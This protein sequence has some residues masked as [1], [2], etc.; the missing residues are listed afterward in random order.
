MH[1]QT[2]YK[3]D[4]KMRVK[5]FVTRIG[6]QFHDA[7]KGSST[8][9]V[10]AAAD[11]LHPVFRDAC[12]LE[13]LVAEGISGS[14]DELSEHEMHQQ[15]VPQVETWQERRMADF[16]GTY[17]TRL[18]HGHASHRLDVIVPAAEQGRVD[19]LVVGRNRRVW[20]EWDAINSVA[21]SHEDHQSGDVDLLDETVRATLLHGG[22]VHATAP[23]NLIEGA[24]AAAIL[25]W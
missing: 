10:L 8:P 19:A 9:L 11:Y 12:P 18:A 25:R 23:E 4:H 20:G 1:G 15:A 17:A 5:E 6:K 14:P 13:L 7:L 2:S 21:S 3:D 16:N 22:T 24:P